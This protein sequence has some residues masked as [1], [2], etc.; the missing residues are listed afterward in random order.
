MAHQ[1]RG[2]TLL[3]LLLVGAACGSDSRVVAMDEAPEAGTTGAGKA[4]NGGGAGRAGGGAGST[5][6]GGGAGG[7]AAGS[8]PIAPPDDVISGGTDNDA[9]PPLPPI[10]NIRLRQSGD[11]VVIDFEPVDDARDYR[12]YISPDPS[13]VTVEDDGQVVVKDAIYRCAGDRPFRTRAQDPAA[14]YDASLSGAANTIHDYERNADDA[15]LGYVYLTPGEGRTPVYRMSD[16]NGAGGFQNADWVVPIFDEGNRAEYAPGEDE[17]NRLLGAGYRDDGVA[18]YIPDD[19]DQAVFR[20]LYTEQWNGTPAV[21][22]THGAEYDAREMDDPDQVADF[23]E[24][25]KILSEQAE[26]SVPLHRVLYNGNSTFDVLAAGK[27]RYERVLDQG[28]QPL[29][30]LHWPGLTEK[31]T[32]VIEALDQGCP[33]PNG[34]IAAQAHAADDFNLPSITLDEARLDTTEVYIN[35]QHEPENRP[36]AIAR[37]FVDVEPK[38]DPDMDWFEG[39]DVGGTWNPFQIDSG[40]NGMF[41]YRNDEWSIDFSGCSENLTIGPMLGQLALGFA[42]YGSS[43]NMSLIPRGVDTQIAADTFM[44]VRM[45]TEVPSTGRRY[46]QIMITTTDELNPGDIQPLDSVPLHSRLGPFPFDMLPPGPERTIVVQPFMSYHELQ[47]QF[48]EGRGWGVSSQCPQANIY[49]HHAGNYEEEWEE[50]WLPVPV[51]G[52]IAGFDRPVQFDVYASTKRVYVFIDD[53]PAGCAELPEGKMPEGDVNVAFRAVLYH[54]GI[55]ESVTPD[56]SPHQYLKRYSL[57]HFDRHM[58]DLGIDR[59]VDEPEWDE[60]RF[61]CATRWYG[62]G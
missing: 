11:N 49:G 55:D 16:P 4:G 1:A 31:T 3:L 60:A 26:G 12:I 48:C 34:Y 9:L 46:P 45:T 47:V 27:A 7:G 58:D 59:A 19:A 5:A 28:N 54:S 30:S 41:V 52:S 10:E 56:D 33:F 39:F 18:F 15:V 50:P 44:H 53:E 23:G 62:G 43:C 36:K 6:T 20:K 24:R 38:P 2:F 61:P 32:L 25:F 37:S 8:A 22:Y 17:R 14:L 13:D 42:D 51:L 21:F 57:S 29:W 35:G 40:N